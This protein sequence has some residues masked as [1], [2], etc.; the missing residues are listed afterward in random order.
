[1]HR[2]QINNVY[3]AT[4]SSKRRKSWARLHQIEESRHKCPPACHTWMLVNA[5]LLRHS[6]HEYVAACFSLKLLVSPR[7]GT[8]ITNHTVSQ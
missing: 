7:F 5:A 1:M 6:E 8:Q 4:T 2:I 3:A